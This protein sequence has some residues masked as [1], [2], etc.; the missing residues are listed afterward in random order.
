LLGWQKG[1]RETSSVVTSR[2]VCAGSTV[3]AGSSVCASSS[4]TLGAGADVGVAA[5][6]RRSGEGRVVRSSMSVDTRRLSCFAVRRD[7]QTEEL[8]EEYP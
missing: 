3:R 6:L 2:R 7:G 5:D 8:E 1:G 4:T